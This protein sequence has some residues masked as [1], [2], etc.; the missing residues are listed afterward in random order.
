MTKM[1]PNDTEMRNKK[2]EKQE[3][4]FYVILHQKRAS[5]LYLM[6]I[7]SYNSWPMYCHGSVNK[8]KPKPT[9]R[10]SAHACALVHTKT[11]AWKQCLCQR[12]H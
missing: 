6:E 10:R 3:K 1:I 9:G 12:K 2:I 4:I 5:I 8:R 11:L 7:I